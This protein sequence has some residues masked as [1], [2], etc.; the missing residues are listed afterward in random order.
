M[1]LTVFGTAGNDLIV[2]GSTLE[3]L[4]GLQGDDTYDLTQFVA[5]EVVEEAA[6]GVDTILVQAG[7]TLP[8]EIENLVLVGNVVA[9][10]VGNAAANRITGDGAGNSL[11][12]L[13]GNDTL[14]GG[15]GDDTYTVDAIGDVVVELAGG[16]NADRVNAKLSYVL[17]ANVEFGSLA[18]PGGTGT[19]LTG[20]ASD[21]VL[22][23]NELAN[24]LDGA[25]G[26]DS[27]QG[28]DGAD[29]LRGGDGNDSLA[30]EADADQI[31]GGNGNDT[32]LGG[33]G[34]DRLLGGAGND[35]LHGEA[36]V[37]TLEGGAGNDTYHIVG[38]DV[39]DVIVEGV[40]AGF[41]RVLI[42]ASFASYTV[43][44][45]VEAAVVSGGTAFQL[46][47]NASGNT[48]VTD[49][50]ADR[51]DGLGG[52]D[53]L[54]GGAG[55]DT[56]LGGAGN[57]SYAV[58]NTGD[59]VTELAREGTDQ[60]FVSLANYVLPANVERVWLLAGSAAR[61]AIGNALDNQ[62]T[63]NE[64]ANRL[65]AGAGNDRLDGR[66]GNDT[67]VGGAGND[68]YLID[69][70]G[71]TIIE[72]AGAGSDLALVGAD[73]AWVLS[74]N[75][76]S[77]TVTALRAELTGN[78]G[79]NTLT[80][81]AGGDSLDGGVGAD[82]L[83]GLGGDDSYVVDNAGD[84]V[85]ELPGG[86]SDVV[87]ARTS[88]TLPANVERLVAL[89]AGGAISLTGGA[90]NDRIEG[91]GSANVLSGAGGN[92]TLI[93]GGGDDTLLGGD[94]NDFLEGGAGFDS[95]VGG[96]GND[97][98]VFTSNGD[99]VVE[100]TGRDLLIS[101]VP[102][103]GLVEVSLLVEDVQ[104]GEAPGVL[105]VLANDLDNRL[106][107]NSLGNTLFGAGGNDFLDGQGGNDTTLGGPGNDTH[108]VSEAG[109]LA[110]ESA[111]Q[112]I[113]TVLTSL[114]S[115]TL[116]ANIEIVRY[117]GQ[118]A[119][120]LIGNALDNELYGGAGADSLAGGAGADLMVG[121]AGDDSYALDAGDR[122][123]EAAGG[124]ID[125]VTL[126]YAPASFVLPANVE[127]ATLTVASASRVTGNA[128]ANVLIGA[129][130]NDTLDGG[131]GNDSLDGGAGNDS[132][133]GGA[134]DD[135]YRVNAG[136]GAAGGQVAGAED[137][138][139]ETATGGRD[140]VIAAVAGGYT[141]P[142][143]VEVLEVNSAPGGQTWGGNALANLLELTLPAGGT[144]LPGAG[145]LDVVRVSGLASGTL[146]V[147]DPDGTDFVEVAL[148]A[149][150]S[151]LALSG[152]GD[153]VR[154]SI[155]SGSHTATASFAAN[156]SVALTGAGS[157]TLQG[158]ALGA[159]NPYALTDY[160]GTLTLQPGAAGGGADVTTLTLSD[161]QGGL[162][163]TGIERYELLSSGTVANSLAVGGVVQALPA[164]QPGF[165]VSGDAALTLSGLANAVTVLA[166]QFEGGTL[167]LQA[168]TAGSAQDW[169]VQ[170]DGVATALSLSWG[171]DSNAL[172][173][174]TTG[175]QGGSAVS[176]A[177]EGTAGTLL[178][179][180]SQSLAVT[181][182]SL[183]TV[184]VTLGGPD[185][186]L[187]ASF[188]VPVTFTVVSGATDLALTGSSGD[189]SFALGNSLTS[190]DSI[191]GG[192][193]T[194]SVSATL[195]AAAPNE[196]VA[197]SPVLQG[198]ENVSL[199]VLG[200]YLFDTSAVSA[201]SY[202]VSG[203][204]VGTRLEVPAGAGSWSALGFV[205]IFVFTA[206]PDAEGVTI[207]GGVG[208]DSVVGSTGDDLIDLRE[209]TASTAAGGAGSDSFRFS[210]APGGPTPTILDF[211]SGEDEI[212]LSKAVMAA[213]TGPGPLDP[214]Q[215]N[216]SAQINASFATSAGVVKYV[217]SLGELY[218]DADATGAGVPLQIAS[219]ENNGTNATVTAADMT[220]V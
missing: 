217:P 19:S 132:M 5:A 36:G 155:A 72:L 29:T 22:F 211:V 40:G 25:L 85:V 209:G 166:R 213:L 164:G 46:V 82:R 76:E 16:G 68:T 119:T 63:G 90:G 154:L 6:G 184:N 118:G 139:I 149:G 33:A 135:T 31:D 121:G 57:D 9:T 219:F 129:G 127:N 212:L 210:V 34:N 103:L 151:T 206:S 58:D 201:A 177:G 15:G 104:L 83:V 64:F 191:N 125:L 71:D 100:T 197:L 78:R 30:G 61:N 3:T 45:N 202:T 123:T 91:N 142:D 109:D 65:E 2:A 189:D 51:L 92:D 193:G 178:L 50:G 179:A 79:N 18:V 27:L 196:I 35:D 138:I 216:G 218:Y 144:V 80:G 167:A 171:G 10:L 153:D 62:M 66:A 207:V 67:L 20:N 114:S 117:P 130:G 101:F 200:Q 133:I 60:V 208:R 24:L 81:G 182:V 17:A 161:V 94:G 131:A 84:V 192:G 116:P 110:Q 198:I 54:D 53:A 160:T 12:G 43:P 14:I 180:G 128:A 95:M 145:T 181:G 52:D 147:T 73:I 26:N 93:G 143:F 47:G 38:G 74:D 148:A 96:A 111:S 37:D 136:N 69:A 173:L 13:A 141:L 98:Y 165:A 120:S 157:L 21:N 59:V 204:T 115:Y 195:A 86:G 146:T 23:G 150:S 124:G 152:A 158:P 175:T 137:V 174:D 55:A 70:A 32:L 188:D 185:T 106:T 7:F 205:G 194:D 44:A 199:T 220:V 126:L 112:G 190:A 214:A 88:F 41:D 42:A 11:D 169:T 163:G 183:P 186:S 102:A 159:G 162:S 187:M 97:T 168:G 215:F 48:L 89:S 108:V 39:V 176:L 156:A 107:G 49:G 1:S 113:D 28:G 87:Y 56:M 99:R 203:N 170:L 140:R 122:V 172:K 77:A 105:S 4:V 134:G 8:G 75:V